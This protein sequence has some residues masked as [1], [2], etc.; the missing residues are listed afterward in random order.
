MTT[1]RTTLIFKSGEE[2]K[3]KNYRPITCL[4]T[5]YKLTTLIVTERVYQHVIANNILPFEQKGCTRE[6]RGCKEQLMLD[7]NIM[8][9]V[10]TQRRSISMMWVDY[11]KAYDSVPH[12]WIKKVLTM[13]KIDPVINGF[14]R[15]TMKSWKLLLS[16]PNKKGTIELDECKIKRGIFEG[17]GIKG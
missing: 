13:Y 7:K 16:L 15:T 2:N 5:M 3:A 14:I 9:V 12:T 4:L 10:K 1:G 8:E 17:E 11:K 6:A